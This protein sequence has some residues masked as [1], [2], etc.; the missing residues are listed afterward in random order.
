MKFSKDKNRAWQWHRTVTA[1]L[2]G[3]WGQT[4][5]HQPAACLAAGMDNSIPGFIS[6]STANRRM[7]GIIPPYSVI[8]RPLL[9]HCIQFC[10]LLSTQE[11]HRSNEASSA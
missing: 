4:A 7:E 5:E 3:P 2:E 9:K 10:T 11:G 1:W 6:R 8:I